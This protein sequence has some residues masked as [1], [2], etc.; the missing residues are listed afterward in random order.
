MSTTSQD[1]YRISDF[2]RYLKT[3]Y[4]NLYSQT[5]SFRLIVCDYSWASMHSIV[6]AFNN[7]SMEGYSKKKWQLSKNETDVKEFNQIYSK[8]QKIL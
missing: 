7:Q 2:F 4:E 8:T 6:E 3:D 1:V 5:L